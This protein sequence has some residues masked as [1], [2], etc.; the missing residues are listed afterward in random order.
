MNEIKRY[1]LYIIGDNYNCE[2]TKEEYE[3]GD[4][5]KY[6]DVEKLIKQN[7][8]LIETIQAIIKIGEAVK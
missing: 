4:W 7:K 3:D 1:Y 2:I 5:C 6:S 8:D